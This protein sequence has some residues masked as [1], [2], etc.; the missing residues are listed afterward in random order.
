[1]SQIHI[2]GFAKYI[3]AIQKIAYDLSQDTI[4]KPTAMILLEEQLD[5]MMKGRP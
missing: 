1:L 3:G 5:L 4:D 2:P